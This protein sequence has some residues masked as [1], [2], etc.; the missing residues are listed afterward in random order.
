MARPAK[1]TG[2]RV[3]HA[4]KAET[5]ERRAREDAMRGDGANLAP[6]KY[7]S[8][9]QKKIFA[10]IVTELTA[11]EILGELDVYVLATAAIA[12]DRLE[13]IEK[14]INKDEKMLT[15]DAL[16]RAKDKYARDFYKCCQELCLSPQA[17]AKMSASAAEM[18]KPPS[19]LEQ[20]LGSDDG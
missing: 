12:I 8:A 2:A 9:H 5:D 7:L 16:L 18:R 6:P 11:S 14:K 3:G 13:Q 20:I 1:A 10:K 4:S 19:K 17:R 15:D